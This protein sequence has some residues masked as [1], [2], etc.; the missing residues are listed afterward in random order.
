MLARVFTSAP[1]RVVILLLAVAFAIDL[2]SRS[3]APWK[4]F[5][6]TSG[7]ALLVLV[8]YWLLVTVLEQRPVYELDRRAALPQLLLGVGL[9]VAVSIPHIVRLLVTTG[10]SWTPKPVPLFL[11]T[12]VLAATSEEVLFRGT[13]LRISEDFLGTIGAL[14]LSA[15][16]FALLHEPAIR[17]ETLIAGISM[18][19][20]FILTRKLWLSIGGHFA[21]NFLL[22]VL[23]SGAMKKLEA[24]EGDFQMAVLVGSLN[25]VVA[26]AFLVVAQREGQLR[27]SRFL[28][29][30]RKAAP[31]D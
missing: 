5:A 29:R 25:I 30:R 26:I 24:T 3:G 31:V 22:S 17:T 14:L 2:P 7:A 4:F 18:G 15:I 19:A 23:S 1:I 12:A 10:A 9:G 11:G 6:E 20:C 28:R 21:H 8:L 13:V 27:S 16:F